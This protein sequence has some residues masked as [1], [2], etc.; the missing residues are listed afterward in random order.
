MQQPPLPLQQASHGEGGTPPLVSPG[1]RSPRRTPDPEDDVGGPGSGGGHGHH[2]DKDAKDGPANAESIRGTLIN[3]YICYAPHRLIEIP[4]MVAKYVAD[5]L[6]LRTVVVRC[7]GEFKMKP[8]DF[9]AQRCL[10]KDV[11]TRLYVFYA[12]YDWSKTDNVPELAFKYRGMEPELFRA[13][14]VKYG[15]EP[16]PL[17]LFTGDTPAE[18]IE[19]E[20]RGESVKHIFTPNA[21]TPPAFPPISSPVKP[22]SESFPMGP[23]ASRPSTSPAGPRSIATPVAPE[24]RG[25]APRS[26][27]DDSSA[28]YAQVLQ[29]ARF[30]PASAWRDPSQR[31]QQRP[32]ASRMDPADFSLL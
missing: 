25:F 11:R 18:R 24:P 28:L 6:S 5:Q 29:R 17:L 27:G 30:D 26:D 10:E 1:P 16:M 9:E 8:A 15:D 23:P 19:R 32:L 3:F 31:Q 4:A 20:A 7:M 13:L 22:Q 14:A 21:K 12:Y 2:R